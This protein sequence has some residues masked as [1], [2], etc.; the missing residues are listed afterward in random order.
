VDEESE[1]VH[2]NLVTTVCHR[3]K[4]LVKRRK[5]L[6]AGDSRMTNLMSCASQLLKDIEQLAALTTPPPPHEIPD[7]CD[8][9]DMDY[10][11][12]ADYLC[13]MSIYNTLRYIPSG[14]EKDVGRMK[15]QQD[16]MNLKHS[17]M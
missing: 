13:A 6:D 3:K 8:P 9:H 16:A 11:A 14:R 1:S 15:L 7:P 17:L 5:T 2:Q 12:D 4:K 10:L